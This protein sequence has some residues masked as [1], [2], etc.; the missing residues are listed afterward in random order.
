MPMGLV[1]A[2]VSPKRIVH[3]MGFGICPIT[4]EIPSMRFSAKGYIKYEHGRHVH[5]H[6]RD[7]IPMLDKHRQGKQ[8]MQV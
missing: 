4:R 5:P 8:I 2:R 1:V 7:D 6:G 3:H